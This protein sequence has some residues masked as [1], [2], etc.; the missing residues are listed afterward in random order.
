MARS[1]SRST[2]GGAIRRRVAGLVVAGLGLGALLG[3]IFG[4]DHGGDS[5]TDARVTSLTAPRAVPKVA[6][7]KST[8]LPV[9]G[10]RVAKPAGWQLT[11]RS[12]VAKLSTDDGTVSLAVSNA[13]GPHQQQM[14]RRYEQAELLR[15]FKPA[16]VVG[17]QRGKI[18]LLPALSTEIAGTTK[19]RRPLR[20]L[21]TAVSTKYRTYS[22]QVFS[23]PRP[24]SAHLTEV[25]AI[26]RAVRFSKPKS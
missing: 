6:L 21:T 10:V 18:G 26:L 4:Q 9:L 23:T 19:Q 15:L 20:I 3:W 25:Q 16:Q 7:G 11:Q 24:P 17:R 2:R 22:V 14:V 12:G 8:D 1:P 5:S 13:G